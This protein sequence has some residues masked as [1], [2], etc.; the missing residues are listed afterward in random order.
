M[1][2]WVP[3]RGNLSDD[4]AKESGSETP[5]LRPWAEMKH[6]LLDPAYSNR[7]NFGGLL[8]NLKRMC[9]KLLYVSHRNR[10][11]I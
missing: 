5:R 10:A 7:T 4:L 1:I 8:Q 2:T 11:E 9:V 3:N 6:P